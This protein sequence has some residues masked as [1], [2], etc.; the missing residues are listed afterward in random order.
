M[1]AN[2]PGGLGRLPPLVGNKSGEFLQGCVVVILGFV[3]VDADA[4]PHTV[5]LGRKL[6]SQLAVAQ[7]AANAY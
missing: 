7:G 5:V 6:D 2:S 1:L 3:G 4:G